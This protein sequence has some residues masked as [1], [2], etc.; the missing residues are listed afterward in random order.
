MGLHD[1]LDGFITFREL[2]HASWKKRPT[3]EVPDLT[4]AIESLSKLCLKRDWTTIDPL[5]IGGLLF[6]ACRL[7]QL[8]GGDADQE[9]LETTHRCIR[10]KP[11]C[12]PR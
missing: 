6:D 8:T 1:A 3:L 5:G 9:L 11:T 2:E 12:V 7:S 4:S 10:E